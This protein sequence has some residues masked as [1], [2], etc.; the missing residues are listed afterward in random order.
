MRPGARLRRLVDAAAAVEAAGLVLSLVRRTAG[1]D[2]VRSREEIRRLHGIVAVWSAPSLRASDR[3]GRG[4]VGTVGCLVLGPWR[5]RFARGAV[6][7]AR[8]GSRTIL[9]PEVRGGLSP[10]A[11][12]APAARA[13]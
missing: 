4:R 6:R 7:L 13:C 5:R 1:I 3:T 11:E 9:D 12:V 10:L 2:P 8:D